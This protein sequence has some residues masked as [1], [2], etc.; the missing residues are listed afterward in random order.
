MYVISLTW[1]QYSICA[2]RQLPWRRSTSVVVMMVQVLC[3]SSSV[4]H[5]NG[6]Q[7]MCCTWV[8]VL[9]LKIT[10]TSM[11]V[12]F[13]ITVASGCN[14]RP[15]YIFYVTAQFLCCTPVIVVT[16]QFLWCT[17]VILG[18]LLTFGMAVVQRC[19]SLRRLVI[20][21][22]VHVIIGSLKKSHKDLT[23][24]QSTTIY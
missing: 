14:D 11:Y 12:F 23:T 7:T 24:I 5:R 17:S 6:W 16:A 21:H 1:W 8:F 22:S 9:T 2:V 13:M 4:I 10:C 18:C 19:V 20:V 3:S 15:F